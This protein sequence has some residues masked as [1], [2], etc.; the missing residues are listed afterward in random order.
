MAVQCVPPDAV[1]QRS[2]DNCFVEYNSVFSAGTAFLEHRTAC[3][4]RLGRVIL[5]NNS[6]G[7]AGTLPLILRFYL[8]DLYLSWSL[9]SK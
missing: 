8:S 6:D 2:I 9:P 5:S 1:G 3:I 4:F 7:L